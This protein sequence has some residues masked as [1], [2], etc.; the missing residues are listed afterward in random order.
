[1]HEVFVVLSS[2]LASSVEMVEALTIVLAVGLTRGWRS[3]L[4]GTAAALILLAVI[5]ALFGPVLSRLPLQPL[6]LIVGALLLIFGVQW[7]RKAMLRASGFKAL[8]DEDATFAA[9][10]AAAQAQGAVRPGALDTYGVALTFKSVLLEG[11]EVA[12]IVVTFGASAQQL[13]LAAWG[14]GA[15]LVVVLALGLLI[16]RPLS[17][18][19]EN[20]LKF[21]VGVML[22][23]F[24]T[25][26]AAEGAGAVWPGGDAAILGLLVVY[27]AA[28]YGFVTWLRRRHTARA[29]RT[30][31]TA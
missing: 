28:S 7:W 2:F 9:E 11:L 14:A 12:F 5:V 24:G 3:A 16:H 21:T 31:V 19:P 4:S 29:A 20:T 30:E 6:R 25:F 1:M 8:H 17:Q 23:T 10:T 26:W 27:A 22:T 18:V 13:G 15:A